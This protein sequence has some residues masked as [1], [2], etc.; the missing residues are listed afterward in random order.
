MTSTR[1]ALIVRG[2]WEGHAS[3]ATTELF[4]DFLR[5]QGFD[6]TIED[7]LE[8]YADP[9]VMQ[10]SDLIIQCWTMGEILPEELAGLRSAIANGAGFA[11]WHGGILDSFRMS[12]GYTQLLGAQFAAHPGDL[13]EHTIDVVPER[14]QHEIV[15]GLPTHIQLCSEQYWLVTDPLNDILATTT[16]PA[17]PETGWHDPIVSPAV[18]TRRWG[19]GRIFASS[20]GHQ[21]ADLQ[22][23]AVRTLTQRGLLWAAQQKLA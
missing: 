14:A 4:T 3:I 21:V 10:R 9:Q 17:Q 7:S 2:G 20:I 11:G 18:W 5:E 16:I 15:R 8:V 19:Q 6:L 13:T 23:P 12:S 1:Q 22:V